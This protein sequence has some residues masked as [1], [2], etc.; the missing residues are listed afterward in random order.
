MWYMHVGG[1]AGVRVWGE[2]LLCGAVR[3]GFTLRRCCAR[4]GKWGTTCQGASRWFEVFWG[5]R[6]AALSCVIRAVYGVGSRVCLAFLV[7]IVGRV[8][9]LGTIEASI[10][11]LR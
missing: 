5:I 9:G 7:Y 3:M 1:G 4:A 8:S 11:F 6:D 10:G 2:L